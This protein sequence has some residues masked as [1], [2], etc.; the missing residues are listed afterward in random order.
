MIW[1]GRGCV[2]MMAPGA[3]LVVMHRPR[4]GTPRPWGHARARRGPRG[5]E[6]GACR[7]WGWPWI[8]SRGA[9]P[10]GRGTG[11]RATGGTRRGAEGGR[12]DGGGGGEA[13]HLWPDQ[14]MSAAAQDQNIV[15]VVVTLEGGE[16]A[17]RDLEI[18]QF[19]L[20]RG[21]GEQDLPGHRFEQR[22]VV[23]LVRQKLDAVPAVVLR[24]A[25]DQ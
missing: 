12:G 2:Q 22:A 20:L 19:R 25:V 11:A 4:A 13:A 16:A 23:L 1:R 5:S 8:G 24:F 3:Q 17:R 6:A 21:I 9:W 18:A 15:G 7:G 14:A 10:P